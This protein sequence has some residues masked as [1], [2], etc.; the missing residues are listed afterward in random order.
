[1]LDPG[2]TNLAQAQLARDTTQ[3]GV[4]ATK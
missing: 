3:R 1:L 2:Q 4:A